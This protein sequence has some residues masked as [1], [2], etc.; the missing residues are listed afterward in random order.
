MSA[1]TKS[2]R[3]LPPLLLVLCPLLGYAAY[4]GLMYHW[5]GN[6]FEGFDAQKAYPNW[7]SNK[8]MF[9]LAGFANALLNVG[10][11]DGMVDRVCFVLFLGLL[12]A[13]W[14]L[15]RTWFWYVLPAGLVPAVTSWFMSYRRYFMVCFPVFVTLAQLIART[16]SRW[17]FWGCVGLLAALQAWAVA[18]FVN[19]GWAG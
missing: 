6:P 10:S 19:F 5:T 7:P 14:T 13:V 16:K 1:G 9:N 4:L 8:N 3:R 18:R 2:V 17:P 12:P 15:N 11:V